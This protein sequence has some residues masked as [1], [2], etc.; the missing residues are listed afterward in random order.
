MVQVINLDE[1]LY[2]FLEENSKEEALVLGKICDAK[3]FENY[4]RREISKAL[5]SLKQEDKVTRSVIEGKVYYQAI[6]PE[7]EPEPIVEEPEET[8]EEVM[9]ASDST[10]N[11]DN[12]VVEN[13]VVEEAVSP[14][15]ELTIEEQ[16]EQLDV[17]LERAKSILKI[18]LEDAQKTNEEKLKNVREKLKDLRRESSDLGAMRFM[19]KKQIDE[20]IQQAQYDFGVL[21]V[22]KDKLIEDFDAAV[23]ALEEKTEKK[24]IELTKALE[25]VL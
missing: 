19:R 23:A 18:E 4:P 20:E 9:E 22:N 1:L 24:R 17:E 15:R 12:S 3:K 25:E 13:A 6:L 10:Q 5:R 2:E 11:I 7:P 14:E 16:I 21:M 8:V